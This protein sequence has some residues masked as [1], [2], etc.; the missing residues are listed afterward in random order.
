MAHA[1]L[2]AVS[3]DAVI[4]GQVNADFG[5]DDLTHDAIAVQVQQRVVLLVTDRG[6]VGVKG[7]GHADASGLQLCVVV[8]GR[9]QLGREVLLRRILHDLVLR[10]GRLALLQLVQVVAGIGVAN[11]C[12]T[13]QNQNQRHQDGERL[14]VHKSPFLCLRLCWHLV[15]ASI[16]RGFIAEEGRAVGSASA[17]R[18]GSTA[19]IF[20]FTWHC[21][22]R[23]EGLAVRSVA[24]LPCTKMRCRPMPL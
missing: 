4:Y 7:V 1:V 20:R 8:H 24:R 17:R 16:R 11:Q 15:G 18:S 3:V 13:R 9:L 23:R 6:R 10:L 2:H 5:D 22:T 19:C 14:R 21:S 12:H